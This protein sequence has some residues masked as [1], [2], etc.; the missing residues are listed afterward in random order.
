MDD[1]HILFN[2]KAALY[3]KSRP[4]YSDHV[5]EYMTEKLNLNVFDI[6][7][8]IGAGTGQLTKLLANKFNSVYAIEPNFSM[9]KECKKNL[10]SYTNI[11]YECCKAESTNLKEHILDYITVAQAFHLFYNKKTFLEFKRIL[12]PNGK[13]MIVFN[14]K[15]HRSDFFLENERVLLQYCP[16][17]KRE[18][19][20]TEFKSDTF[21]DFFSKSSYHFCVYK[22]DNTEFLDCNTFVDRTLSA[23]YSITPES[24][25]Y[26]AYI[27]GLQNVY[28]RFAVNNKIKMELSTVIYSGTLR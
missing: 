27:H 12:K 20:A 7:A 10:S 1:L 28:K 4:S 15:N 16:L 21:E 2:E 8:D 26:E 24:P 22:N 9:L 18:F 11:I 3:A 17:Y 14:M 13:L 19:H 25:S 6:G 23:S 5:I